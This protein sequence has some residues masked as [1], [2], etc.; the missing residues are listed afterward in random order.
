MRCGAVAVP[1]NPGSTVEEL[2]YYLDDSEASFLFLPA[3]APDQFTKLSH[4]KITAD[5]QGN[6]RCSHNSHGK[7][8]FKFG[9][10]ACLMIYTSGTTSRPKGV[11]LTH[12]HLSAGTQAF[13][14]TF[15]LSEQ[16]ATLVPM[17]LF[18]AHGLIGGT[19]S[20]FA[21]GGKVVLQPKFSASKFW[22][23]V[24][25]H[26]VTWYSGSPTIHRILLTRVDED[27]IPL[28]QL[29]FIRS[30]SASLGVDTL[31][32]MEEK[33]GAPVLEGYG[34][35]ESTIQISCNPLPPGQRK[36]ASVGTATGVEV[37]IVNEQ[38]KSTAIGTRGQIA[39]RGAPIMSGYHRRP[40]ADESSFVDGWF[41]TGDEGYFDS[42]GYLYIVGRIKELIN[43]GGEKISPVEV[44]EVL[45]RHP[46]VTD[47]A[48]FGVPD[49]KYGEQVQAVV[50]LSDNGRVEEILAFCAE[51]ISALKLP[52]KIHLV[53]SIPR[54]ATNKVQS[55]ELASRF[56]GS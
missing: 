52:S 26:Q 8:E 2:S 24:K 50:V 44:E 22:N 9:S 51:H 5:T 11:P 13:A 42:D 25:E 3:D 27:E 19:L 14:G 45:L 40:D 46:L 6:L 10:D 33:F 37:A 53:E 1:V 39:V 48:C 7:R 16:D 38:G 29:R 21:T 18:H 43:R 34:M 20:T 30:S 4:P 32:N 36:P 35:T 55:K 15:N 41:L 28:G 49:T 47:A 31:Q 56:A 54:T 17:P 12:S 23:Q